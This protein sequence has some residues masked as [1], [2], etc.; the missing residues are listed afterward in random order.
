MDFL[1][2]FELWLINSIY[3]LCK[4]FLWLMLKNSKEQIW[5]RRY[6]RQV[7][8]MKTVKSILM[9]PEITCIETMLLKSQP[10]WAEHLSRIDVIA[11]LR[12]PYMVNFPLATVTE[13]HQRNVLK[14]PSRRS[15]VPATLTATNGRLLLL[16]I[17]P[18][19]APSTVSSPALKTPAGLTSGRNA[20]GGR[21]REPQQ[22]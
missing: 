3:S 20:E 15:S 19:A 8:L 17:R 12:L 10:R 16:T 18:C 4:Y 14:I 11:S 9:F 2:E 6:K 1:T 22:P 13:W 5:P 7:V 21:S